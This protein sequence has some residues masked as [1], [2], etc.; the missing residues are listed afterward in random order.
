MIQNTL[1]TPIK[2][3]APAFLACAS[4]S[5]LPLLPSRA[6]A[7][8]FFAGLRLP[9]SPCTLVLLGLVCLPCCLVSW[10]VCPAG[11]VFS[12]VFL[13]AWCVWCFF[14]LFVRLLAFVGFASRHTG[15]VR[16]CILLSPVQ[17]RP[18]FII[19]LVCLSADW[20]GS[21]VLLT[22]IG[23]LWFCFCVFMYYPQCTEVTKDGW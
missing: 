8:S 5:L 4:L 7:L 23:L 15:Q 22:S 9:S 14:V 19:V 10:L 21:L 20:T 18:L 17:L 1:R 13:F 2:P 16:S 3:H 6:P 11:V 12:C